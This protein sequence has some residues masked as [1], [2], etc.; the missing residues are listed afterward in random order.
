MPTLQEY[1]DAMTA[2]LAY[3]FD[4]S[5]RLF[6]SGLGH[7][8]PFGDL[9]FQPGE[10]LVR[11]GVECIAADGE[12]IPGP[13]L[14]GSVHRLAQLTET[15]EKLRI[16]PDG[17]DRVDDRSLQPVDARSPVGELPRRWVAE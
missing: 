7:G 5:I 6:V 10:G 8:S 2:R 15:G 14:V 3:S 17:A 11:S 4:P 16:G 12:L 13:G 1:A 9:L